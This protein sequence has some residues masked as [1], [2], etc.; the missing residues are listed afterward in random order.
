MPSDLVKGPARR[1]SPGAPRES[2][3]SVP[4]LKR[5]CKLRERPLRDP[6]A[7]PGTVAYALQGRSG[8]DQRDRLRKGSR[9]R[10]ESPFVS[11]RI[12]FGDCGFRRPSASRRRC[13]S[14]FLRRAKPS[15]SG[16]MRIGRLGVRGAGISEC[17]VIS[18]RLTYRHDDQDPQDYLTDQKT[19]GDLKEGGE[20]CESFEVFEVTALDL[21]RKVAMQLMDPR[22]LLDL[23][24]VSD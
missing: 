18:S 13:R 8:K 10:S 11:L 5:L 1:Q 12:A 16:S 24:V 3:N 4:A 9:R 21:H 15:V 20:L 14:V 22:R 7:G 17:F 23:D 2:D 19:T 6:L